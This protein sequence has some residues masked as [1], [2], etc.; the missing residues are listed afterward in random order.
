MHT[1]P[2]HMHADRCMAGLRD[3]PHS[4]ATVGCHCPPIDLREPHGSLLFHRLPPAGA[5][6]WPLLL[7]NTHMRLLW[8]SVTSIP[9]H[10]GHPH[11]ILPVLDT[12][13]MAFPCYFTGFPSWCD[14]KQLN[15]G[16]HPTHLLSRT[17][18][19]GQGVLSKNS[20][21]T[22][23]EIIQHLLASTAHS[24]EGRKGQR[25]ARLLNM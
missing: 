4:K 17:V 22:R 9:G 1:Q 21:A 15:S 20:G 8:A 2:Y 7:C 25:G 13:N 24:G 18:S 5:S 12:K 19:T 6:R 11:S 10:R 14:R 23:M 3:K 16:T